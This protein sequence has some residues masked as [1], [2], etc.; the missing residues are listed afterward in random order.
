LNPEKFFP[1]LP[2]LFSRESALCSV[3]F[4]APSISLIPGISP[5]RPPYCLCM[6]S[7]P[8]HLLFHAPSASY[9]L[10]RGQALDFQ[11]P[12]QFF[13]D[14]H[15]FFARP[16][17]L[18]AL[19]PWPFFWEASK[20]SLSV[21]HFPFRPEQTCKSSRYPTFPPSPPAERI[22]FPFSHQGLFIPLHTWRTLP[23]AFSRPFQLEFLCFQDS[24][25]KF[26]VCPLSPFS[27]FRFSTFFSDKFSSRPGP[28]SVCLSPL[29]FSRAFPL[30]L[31]TAFLCLSSDYL[32]NGSSRLSHLAS[33][34][35]WNSSRF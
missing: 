21:L 2:S 18:G 27:F 11:P 9:H 3:L 10:E 32:V 12:P 7:P 28:F 8:K 26:P 1:P 24:P 23:N 5:T 14:G 25:T 29:P 35:S 31:S 4:S 13:G 30:V 33:V 6:T 20:A 22:F 17:I 34:L 19:R 15:F 16:L